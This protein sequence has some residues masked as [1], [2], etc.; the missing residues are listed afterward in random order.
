M[1]RRVTTNYHIVLT[2]VVLVA[3]VARSYGLSV[4]PPT[5]DEAAAAWAAFNY[6]ET[7]IFGQVMWYHPPLRNFVIS[8]SG[9]LF[10]GYTAWGLRF[11]SVLFGSLTVL[12]TGCLSYAFFRN[13]TASL[14]AAFFLCIDPL[15]IALSREAFQETTTAFFIVAG[16]L[17]AY[18][19]IKKDSLFA[20]YLSGALFGLA[21]ASKWHGLFP[22][23]ASAFAYLFA[24]RL[25]PGFSGEQRFWPRFA[26]AVSAYLALPAVI[27]TAVY[28]P[29]LFRGYSLKE[30]ASFQLW[31]LKHQYYYVSEPYTEQYLSHEA[32]QWFLWPVAWVDFVFHQGKAYLNIAMGNFLVWVLTLPSLYVLIKGWLREKIFEPGFLIALFLISYLPLILTTRSIWVFAAPAVIPF[33]FLMSGYAVARVM[34]LQKITTKY[35]IIYLSAVLTLSGLMYP[36][37]TFRALEF[38]IYRPLAELYTPHRDAPPHAPSPVSAP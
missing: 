21:S 13:K 2:V 25:I 27:Y 22:W 4:Q 20:V 19:G 23:A 15:H 32:Y 1:I 3:A 16:V 24:P 35:L 28:V 9:N 29:W 12:L 26:T 37:A 7:G 31:L 18:S 38:R 34:A 14:L 17:A 6:L 33:A 36:M 5:D 10:N 8:F 30:F 11:G